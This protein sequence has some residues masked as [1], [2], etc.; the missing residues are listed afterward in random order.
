M[1]DRR[2]PLPL[3]YQIKERL[4]R[5]L[6]EPGMQLPSEH[7]LMAR[8][9]V[10]RMTVVQ[11]LKA[12]AGD[13]M[14]HRIQGKGTFVAPGKFQ[15]QLARMSGFT[16]ELLR[17]GYVPRT[18][19][20]SFGDIPAPPRVA[21]QLNLAPDEAV[22]R[23]VRLRLIGEGP[24][25]HQVA[26]LPVHLCPTLTA[27]GLDQSLYAVVKERFDLIPARAWETYE[28]KVAGNDTI[29]QALGVPPGAPL[30]ESL[31][32]TCGPDDTPWEY[33]HSHIRGDRYVLNVELRGN[34]R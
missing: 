30:L 15:Q 11:A 34:G 33:V 2:S 7:E 12:L 24:V 6:P 27:E 14:I 19:L 20:L 13:G 4:L 18:R 32:V 23:V 16:E 22:W 3:Y 1:L 26:Y 8:F 28:A 17:K 31:R 29:A 5:E 25:A 21:T 9:K 10:S